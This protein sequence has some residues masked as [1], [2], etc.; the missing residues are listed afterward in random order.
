MTTAALLALAILAFPGGGDVPVS[1]KGKEHSTAAL[2]P[3]LPEPTL[4]AIARWHGWARDAGYR[5]DVDGQ[6][7][8]VLLTPA[9]STRARTHLRT[10]AKAEAWFDATLP[11][12]VPDAAGPSTGAG[13]P[14]P[15]RPVVQPLPEDPEAPPPAAP[16]PGTAAPS[17]V[18]WGSGA[19]GPDSQAAVLIVLDDVEDHAK[20]IDHLADTA[21]GLDDWLA[22]ARKQTGLTLEDPLVGAYVENAPG[23]E[24]W[25]GDHELVNR[26]V[27]LLVLRRFGQQPN[28]LLQGLAWEAEMAFDGSLYCFP[29]RDGFVA[30]TEHT[31]WPSDLRLSFKSRGSR[32]LAVEEFA[33]WKRGTWDPEAARIAWG[34]VHVLA[35]EQ[36]EKPGR[37]SALLADLRL[38]RDELD[39]RPTGPSTWER[40]PNWSMPP[41]RQAELLQ[42]HHGADVLERATTAFRTLK[43]PPATG[44][45]P[46]KSPQTRR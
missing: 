12:V 39:R 36:A 3:G 8:V 33:G 15:A 20:L 44:A 19:S 25:N 43:N 18:A 5:M 40:F 7:R 23:Q 17:A 13:R 45:A 21:R 14:A 46:A 30:V 42:R 10:L 16:K 27:Q 28:W 34:L 41:A 9:E 29:F 1:W 31:G 26:A 22:E 24:E 11:L 32:P 2:P 4:A 38:V 37:L 35:S 6:G